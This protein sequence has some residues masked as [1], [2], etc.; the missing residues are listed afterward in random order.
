MTGWLVLGGLLMAAFA[1]VSL[2]LAAVV[3]AVKAVF[4]L[5]FLPFRLVAWGV[6]AVLMLVGTAVAIVLGLALGLALVLAPLLPFLILAALVYGLVRLV[7]RPAT[8]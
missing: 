1:M 3:M 2:V 4:W 7:K 8:A 5:I 6:G